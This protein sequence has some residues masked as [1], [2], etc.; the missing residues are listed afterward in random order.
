M[1]KFPS[2][3]QH[4]DASRPVLSR[5]GQAELVY[6]HSTAEVVLHNY[7]FVPALDCKLFAIIKSME[8]GFSISNKGPFL[9]LSRGK[10]ANNV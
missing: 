3:L 9:I 8:Q 6:A 1:A 2:P 7:Q 4:K 5:P 10:L